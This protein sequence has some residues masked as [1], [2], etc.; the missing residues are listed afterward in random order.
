MIDDSKGHDLVFA[1]VRLL[2]HKLLQIPWHGIACGLLG[3]IRAVI[4]E[5]A[6]Q[7]G[8]GRIG[9]L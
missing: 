4:E 2:Q 5:R 8:S 1:I 3:H 7:V 6:F 9:G